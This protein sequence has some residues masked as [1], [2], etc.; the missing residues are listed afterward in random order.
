MTPVVVLVPGL[1]GSQLQYQ[2][3]VIW[4]GP[5]RQLWLPYGKMAELLQEDL[6]ATDVIRDVLISSQYSTL[7]EDLN[8]CGF[9]E[10]DDPPTLIVFPYDWRKDNAQAAGLVESLDCSRLKHMVAAHLSQNNNYPELARAALSA[11][12]GCTPDWIAVADQESG[13]DWRGIA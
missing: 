5:V 6:V 10:D 3:E 4:P 1:M 9:R 2:G 7:I 13:L 11:A 8:T 12:L